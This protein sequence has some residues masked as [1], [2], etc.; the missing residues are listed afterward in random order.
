MVDRDA[1]FNHMKFARDIEMPTPE[2]VEKA[3]PAKEEPRL[4]ALELTVAVAKTNAERAI[5]ESET[6]DHEEEK[7]LDEQW[8]KKMHR[9]NTI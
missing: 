7:R 2:V 5:I 6:V 1:M 9:A 3:I 8:K 4:V